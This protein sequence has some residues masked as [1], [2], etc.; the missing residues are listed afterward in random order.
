MGNFKTQKYVPQSIEKKKK[1]D[2]SKDL[3]QKNTFT[4]KNEEK[5]TF[6]DAYFDN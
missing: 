2:F 4:R 6:P 1:V 3:F 5:N